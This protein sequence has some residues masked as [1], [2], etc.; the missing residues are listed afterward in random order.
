MEDTEDWE[1]SVYLIHEPTTPVSSTLVSSPPVSSTLVRAVTQMIGC[2]SI[3]LLPGD[4]RP[5]VLRPG[6]S[7]IPAILQ[8]SVTDNG[9]SDE[10]SNG[11]WAEQI[12][13]LRA[14]STYLDGL[15]NTTAHTVDNDKEGDLLLDITIGISPGHH[16]YPEF[17][18][19]SHY[20]PI[21]HGVM[22][23]CSKLGDPNSLS[24]IVVC[25]TLTMAILQDAEMM[26]FEMDPTRKL[27]PDDLKTVQ[28]VVNMSVPSFCSVVPMSKL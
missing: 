18:K 2:S 3:I 21:L 14:L 27:E 26:R 10:G 7:P 12:I 15:G 13:Y 22:I 28:G 16:Q 4:T 5:L 19:K 23:P 6:L 20:H 11:P 9:A 25:P 24:C 8:G 1:A 17:L